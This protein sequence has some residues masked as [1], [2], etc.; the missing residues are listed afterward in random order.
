M[1]LKMRTALLRAACVGLLIPLFWG[2][3]SFALFNL[4]EGIAS[5]A[6]WLAV[7]LTCPFWLIPG[8]VGMWTMPFLNAA[9]YAAFAW[10][11]V[12]ASTKTAS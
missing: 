10:L 9:M 7:Y 12:K 3:M 6:F 4:K 1:S 11:F 8:A 5:Q 2:V